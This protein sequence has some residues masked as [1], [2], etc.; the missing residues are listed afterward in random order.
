MS[1]GDVGRAVADWQA[2]GLACAFARISEIRGVGSAA[3]GEMAAWNDAGAS[4]ALVMLSHAVKLDVP[5]LA[6][7][8]RGDVSYVGALGSAR[9][10][11]RRAE[12]LRAEGIADAD[13]DRIH[14]P[15]GLD[16]GGNRP[17]SIALAICAEILATRNHRDTVSLRGRLSPIRPVTT[18]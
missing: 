11:A 7:A 18:S 13:I 16:L 2:G 1:S 14:G 9:T 8:L 10:Q 5:V 6:A 4:R 3:T 15:I 17:A 12:R